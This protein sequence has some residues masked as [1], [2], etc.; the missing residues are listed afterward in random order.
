LREAGYELAHR[1][2][3]ERGWFMVCHARR[4]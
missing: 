4:S 3:D 2:T 1:W